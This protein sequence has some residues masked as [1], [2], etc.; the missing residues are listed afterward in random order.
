MNKETLALAQ[1]KNVMHI[2]LL[3]TVKNIFS[4][5]LSAM[6]P[7]HVNHTLNQETGSVE[8]FPLVT[9]G[10]AC[11]RPSV[12]SSDAKDGKTAIMYLQ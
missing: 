10:S 5:G 3:T 7:I 6:S 11:V 9:V 8:N 2:H 12:I 1:T 4:S